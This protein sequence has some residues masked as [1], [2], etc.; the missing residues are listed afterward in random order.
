MSIWQPDAWDLRGMDDARVLSEGNPG[1]W[2]TYGPATREL[3][4]FGAPDGK[5]ISARSAPELLVRM[6]AAR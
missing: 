1:W 5:P 2:V 3:W 4:A 6:R